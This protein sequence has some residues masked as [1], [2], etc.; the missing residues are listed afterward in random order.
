M[1]NLLLLTSFSIFFIG[2]GLQPSTKRIQITKSPQL[3]EKG[4]LL[5]NVSVIPKQWFLH[6]ELKVKG[7]H[8]GYTE[9]L[10]LTKGE[11]KGEYGDRTPF[12][13]S[14]EVAGVEYFHIASAV[15]G[16]VNYY[17][18]SAKPIPLDEWITIEISQKKFGEKYWYAIEINGTLELNM[19]N[20][21]P[22]AFKDVKVYASNP[23]G[24][25]HNGTVIRNSYIDIAI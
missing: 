7:A 20:T 9:I 22:E 25:A 5:T 2:T 13:S 4:K 8:I 24:P 18:D 6:A 19:V 23:F 10:H 14:R 3:I 16:D 1:I 15:N 17:Y 11:N 21:K 12:I